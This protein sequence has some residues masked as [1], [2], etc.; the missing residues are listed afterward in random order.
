MDRIT[1]YAKR[2]I[3]WLLLLG[4]LI[5]LFLLSGCARTRLKWNYETGNVDRI[6]HIPEDGGQD[7]VC[8]QWRVPKP[9][10]DEYEYR[11]LD[12]DTLRRQLFPE[13]F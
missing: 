5:T 13:S 7:Q 9:G 10:R 1:K 2:E 6:I 12:L 3:G 4:L 8:I 11:C